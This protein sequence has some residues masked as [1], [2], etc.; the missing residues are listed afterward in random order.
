MDLIV[1]SYSKDNR[2]IP[3][4]LHEKHS[5]PPEDTS[6]HLDQTTS[7]SCRCEDIKTE[8]DPDVVI[9]EQTPEEIAVENFTTMTRPTL[10]QMLG[11]ESENEFEFV[12]ALK[13]YNDVLSSLA[14]GLSGQLMGS[15]ISRDILFI[16]ANYKR[17]AIGYKDKFL[18]IMEQILNTTCELNRNYFETAIPRTIIPK[19]TITESRR[20]KLLL[21]AGLLNRCD[22]IMNV[23]INIRICVDKSEHKV[24]WANIFIYFLA[25][26]FS[27]RNYDD[28]AAGFII[29]QKLMKIK[30]TQEERN[31]IEGHMYRMLGRNNLLKIPVV[32]AMME[33]MEKDRLYSIRDLCLIY[34]NYKKEQNQRKREDYGDISSSSRR[35]VFRKFNMF[36][37]DIDN[38][39]R[40]R[41]LFQSQFYSSSPL[42]QILADWKMSGVS[43]EH[44]HSDRWSKSYIEQRQESKSNN[45]GGTELKWGPLENE[46][47]IEKCTETAPVIKIDDDDS[48]DDDVQFCT[49]LNEDSK[50]KTSSE[51]NEEAD[52]KFVPYKTELILHSSKYT[53][54]NQRIEEALPV[55]ATRLNGIGK[56]ITE[57]SKKNNLKENATDYPASKTKTDCPSAPVKS[58]NQVPSID[59]TGDTAK[60]SEQNWTENIGK[61]LSKKDKLKENATDNPGSQTNTDCPSAPVNS[62][63]KTPSVNKIGDTA[64]DVDIVFVPEENEPTLNGSKCGETSMEI[65]GNLSNV[66]AVQESP[67][68]DASHNQRIEETLPVKDNAGTITRPNEIV[69][70]ITEPLSKKDKLKEN[71]T[72]NPGSKTN[73]DCPSAPVNSGNKTPSVNKTGD[74]VN[75]T[76][77]IFVPDEIEPILNGSKCG[78]TSMEIDAVQESPFTD[79]TSNNQRIK[80]T[81]PI[82][83]NAGTTTRLNGNMKTITEPNKEVDIIFVSDKNKPNLNGS[84]YGETPME[85]DTSNNQRIEEYLPVKATRLNGIMKTITEPLSDENKLK[86]NVI[87]NSASKI[88]THRSSVSVESKNKSPSVNKTGDMAN[89]TDSI[90]VPEENEPT[91]NGSKCGETSMEIDGNL[92]NVD[93]VQESPFTDA[94]HNQR[95]QETLPVKD[96]AGTITRPNE[97]VRPITE[98]LSKK[99]KLKE[100]GTDNPGSKTNTDCPSASVNSGNKTPSV[101]KTGDTA[102]DTDSIF[103]PDEIEPILNG[104][105]CGETS[106]EIDGNLLTVDA[107]QESPF[108][109][110]TSNNQRIK[111][112]LP[113]KDNAGTTT[114]LNGNMKTITNQ[115]YQCGKTSMEIDENLPNVGA[116]Q[117][118]FTDASNNQR[119]EETLPVKD[120]AETIRPNEIVKTIT[121]TLSNTNI[122]K[123]N[124]TDNPASKTNTEPVKSENRSPFIDKTGD[125]AKNNGQNGRRNGQNH[126]IFIET[127]ILPAMLN[128]TENIGKQEISKTRDS[129]EEILPSVL[130]KRSKPAGTDMEEPF[131]EKDPKTYI[132]G[133]IS[134]SDKENTS[135]A[136]SKLLEMESSQEKYSTTELIEKN[137]PETHSQLSIPVESNRDEEALN[138]SEVNDNITSGNYVEKPM[139]T[140][141][142]EATR[143]CHTDVAISPEEYYVVIQ[144]DTGQEILETCSVKEAIEETGTTEATCNGLIEVNKEHARDNNNIIDRKLHSV[145]NPNLFSNH[146]EPTD[147]NIK[148]DEDN[149]TDQESVDQDPASPAFDELDVPD[150]KTYFES[151]GISKGEG[152]SRGN[153]R[154]S[155]EE[156]GTFLCPNE[157]TSSITGTSQVKP[158]AETRTPSDDPLQRPYKNAKEYVAVFC[159]SIKE[160]CDT[161][162]GKTSSESSEENIYG[163]VELPKDVL[164]STDSA[165]PESIE[166]I[167]KEILK[168]EPSGAPQV[169]PSPTPQRCA[170]TRASTKNANSGSNVRK[171]S[172]PYSD[173]LYQYNMEGA[174]GKPRRVGNDEYSPFDNWSDESGDVVRLGKEPTPALPNG[175]RIS[176]VSANQAPPPSILKVKAEPDGRASKSKRKAPSSNNSNSP[177]SNNRRRTIHVPVSAV[178]K[179]SLAIQM[180]EKIRNSSRSIEILSFMFKNSPS[181]N[182]KSKSNK[183]AKVIEVSKGVNHSIQQANQRKRQRKSDKKSPTKRTHVRFDVK[184][185]AED[186]G[187]PHEKV[188]A[189]VKH[190]ETRTTNRKKESVRNDIGNSRPGRAT[191]KRR[192]DYD[193]VIDT[194][195]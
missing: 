110:T 14:E 149:N 65:D 150:V 2:D 135:D 131:S 181:D 151:Q 189:V 29:F 175:G 190:A 127:C 54:N 5:R 99:D 11:M 139:D 33:K 142:H 32:K 73:T 94:S 6:G 117:S 164:P 156:S 42:A 25:R 89:E 48:D 167:K 100:N 38:R 185:R 7:N 163:F 160:N 174:V 23:L 40:R 143:E 123:E 108:T 194:D 166:D 4:S 178:A 180:E 61:P 27:Y 157:E 107:V 134:N 105:K 81:L 22:R 112:T 62:G 10:Q 141:D 116:V 92:S 121:E 70:P 96:N 82:K 47:V 37:S 171:R 34:N 8:E 13:K 55:K 124:D 18:D 115:R 49:D 1:K 128:R 152:I 170:V 66:D 146:T 59:K 90:F 188:S 51:P 125:T 24:L 39:G 177:S 103:V 63:N 72:D 173:E 165:K 109:D 195:R 186:F 140:E 137:N 129:N 153:H 114:R 169:L 50:V 95:I 28:I 15:V 122:L 58:E 133:E 191:K 161:D 155:V 3:V 136:G 118:P 16:T 44:K 102:N 35:S 119:I 168:T 85:T 77:S 17:I 21:Q 130:D 84:K 71:G 126:L 64:N 60:N 179:T 183:G 93:A 45:N 78:E 187:T 12:E 53:S 69:R 182:D 56:T 192:L 68:T 46:T 26:V 132:N 120:N 172:D 138:V 74:T 145:I 148:T 86:E 76:D 41:S 80:K 144:P 75:D 43:S 158:T 30:T 111:K 36:S 106:M 154:E 176:V 83:D 147:D 79:T 31:I 57:L 162:K 91:L 87:D 88:N 20:I 19:I 97:I 159:A 104:S 101:N 67:F 113:V 193:G 52:T 98:P 9:I 184:D